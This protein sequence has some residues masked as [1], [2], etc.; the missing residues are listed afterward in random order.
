M[1]AAT[2]HQPTVPDERQLAAFARDGYLPWRKVLDDD[3]EAGRP[4][5]RR[6]GIV[7]PGPHDDQLVRGGPGPLEALDQ[8]LEHPVPVPDERADAQRHAGAPSPR[9]RP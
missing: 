7:S 5:Q 4:A 9:V 1:Q 2:A 8:T 3:A 6:S